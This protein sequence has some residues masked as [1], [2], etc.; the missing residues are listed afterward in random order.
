[1]WWIVMAMGAG[2]ALVP[3]MLNPTIG[4]NGSVML[5]VGLLLWASYKLGVMK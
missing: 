4:V 2:F 5:G 3:N 1:M